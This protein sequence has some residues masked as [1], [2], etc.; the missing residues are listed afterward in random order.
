MAT[1]EQRIVNVVKRPE[2][3]ETREIISPIP[4]NVET[5]RRLILE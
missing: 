5:C 3:A 1:V 4:S 2:T